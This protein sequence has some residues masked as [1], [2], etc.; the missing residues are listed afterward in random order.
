MSSETYPEFPSDHRRCHQLSLSSHD[1]LPG[2]SLSPPSGV[3]RLFLPPAIC[4]PVSRENE[5]LN[6]HS[7]GSHWVLSPSGGLLP[8]LDPRLGLG[9]AHLADLLPMPFLLHTLPF[10]APF[11]PSL[12]FFCSP[13]TPDLLYFRPFRNSWSRFSSVELNISLC[14]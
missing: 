12:A 8:C 9:L 1:P 10:L 14:S 4:F 3:Q 2:P 13:N 6:I 7:R 11:S 5:L